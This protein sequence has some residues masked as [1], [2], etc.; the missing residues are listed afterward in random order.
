MVEITPLHLSVENCFL[1]TDDDH[2]VLV[3]TGYEFEWD[4]LF[5]R[6]SEHDMELSQISHILL[7][8]HHNDHSGSLRKIVRNHSSIQVVT[9]YLSKDPLS[10]GENDF[11]EGGGFLNKWIKRTT[12]L[13]LVSLVLLNQKRPIPISQITTTFPPYQ[14]R[15]RDT[16]IAGDTYLRDVG[17][18]L[19]G[20]II[21]TPGHTADSVSILFG[22]GDCLTGDA[23]ENVFA[24]QLLGASYCT[25]VVANMD[26][27]YKSWEK[28]IAAGARQI[29]PGH[30]CPFTVDKLEEN[31]WEHKAENLVP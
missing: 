1:V 27:F 12:T 31:L 18:P 15:Y 16:F 8:H 24:L 11:T 6:L 20:D 21:R 3:D 10:R 5:R 23:A 25:H 9:S 29:Y 2:Y 26:A 19:D 14:L 13:G 4:L 17:I 28:I 7:T 30:G 22:N